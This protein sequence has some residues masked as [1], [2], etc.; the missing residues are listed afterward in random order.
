[1]YFSTLDLRA[2]HF[3]TIS[4]EVEVKGKERQA[5]R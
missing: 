1:M 3:W 2:T 4:D 5:N